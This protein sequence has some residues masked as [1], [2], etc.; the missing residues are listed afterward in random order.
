MDVVERLARAGIRGTDLAARMA[1]EHPRLA[2]L[3]A[4]TL[5]EMVDEGDVLAIEFAVPDAPVGQAGIE[6]F[7]LPAGSALRIVER[8]RRR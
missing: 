2:P 7:Y 5:A 1:A 8:R 4:E 3:L 6:R